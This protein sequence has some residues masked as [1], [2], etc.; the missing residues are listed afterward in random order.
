[1]KTQNGS[2]GFPLILHYKYY[3]STDNCISKWPLK[4]FQFYNL[5]ESC[6][7]CLEV[8]LTSFPEPQP[9]GTL[10]QPCWISVISD[11]LWK[12]DD[13]WYL[14][15]D[16]QGHSLAYTHICTHM[17]Q[18]SYS[19]RRKKNEWTNEWDEGEGK[20]EWYPY[21]IFRLAHKFLN[22]SPCC[23]GAQTS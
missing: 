7:H 1:M 19:R 5:S 16:G 17:H 10:W 21:M 14:R 9:R 12:M 15:N 20:E 8:A 6:H 11:A 13:G 23:K 3:L 18:Y 2:G 4:H 22:Q